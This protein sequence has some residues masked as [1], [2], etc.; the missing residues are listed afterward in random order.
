MFGF[1]GLPVQ[2]T[3]L[4][5]VAWP[6]NCLGV[7]RPGMRC[8]PQSTAGYQAAV[9]VNNE[10]TYVLRTDSDLLTVVW[11]AMEEIEGVITTLE[12]SLIVIKGEGRLFEGSA[13]P[14]FV[15]AEIVPGTQFFPSQAQLQAGQRVKVGLNP[16]PSSGFPVLVWI[17]VVD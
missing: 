10:V 11:I 14:G 1:P 6:D 17:A 15:Q 3:E 16:R 7:V 2:V 12:P 4:E 9:L 5:A 8:T 13:V